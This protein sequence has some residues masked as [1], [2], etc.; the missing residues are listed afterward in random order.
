MEKTLDELIATVNAGEEACGEI[1]KRFPG[2]TEIHW[3]NGERI[4]LTKQ[5]EIRRYKLTRAFKPA[6]EP[7]DIKV[8]EVGSSPRYLS[9]SIFDEKRFTVG[10]QMFDVLPTIDTLSRICVGAVSHNPNIKVN[11]LGFYYEDYEVLWEDADK[12]LEALKKIKLD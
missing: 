2:E 4:L 1:V 5:N 6:F 7:F 3:E 11:R 9:V 8:R 12:L 10:C